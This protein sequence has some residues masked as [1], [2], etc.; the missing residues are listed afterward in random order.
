MNKVFFL[1]IAATVK[2]TSFAQNAIRPT[3][4]EG[5]IW[6]VVSI[7]PAEPPESD[8]IPECYYQDIHGRWGIGIPHTYELKGDTV[9]GGVSYKKMYCDG[10]FV[11]GLREEDGRIYECSWEDVT[12]ALTFDFQLQ[13]GGIVEDNLM[14]DRAQM[15]V[16]QVREVDVDGRT[17]RC[18]DMWIHEVVYEVVQGLVDYWIEG[19]GC[20]NGPHNPFWWDAIGNQAL[21]IS[22]YDGDECIFS[23]ECLA[24]ITGI[25]SAV[26]N[27]P[28]DSSKGIYD[29]QGRR[30]LSAPAKGLYIQNGRKYLV[31]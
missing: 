9:M 16:R 11:S 13:P 3:V 28:S 18:M 22:C 29:L 24:Q 17:Y 21:L 19:V 8:S 5:R 26:A 12:E 15:E 25:R 7:R 27:K 1:L 31:R 20:M 2:M 14:G 23:Q 30:L 4:V 6:N 10:I